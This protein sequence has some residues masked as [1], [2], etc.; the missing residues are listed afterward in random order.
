MPSVRVVDLRRQAGYPLSAPL[1]AEL[2]AVEERGGRA[3]LLLNR[4]GISGAIHCRACGVS[5]RCRSCDVTLTLHRDGRCTAITADTPKRF[6]NS[7]PSV[8]RSSWPGSGGNAAARG[9]ARASRAGARADPARRRHDG[10]RS[11]PRRARAVHECTGGGAD[12]DADGGKGTSLPRVEVAA[13]VDADTGLAF[14]DFRAEERTFQLVTQLAG[15]SGRD[16]PGKV[17]VQT[18]QPDA[19]PFAFAIRHDVA[20]FLARELARR[21]ELSLPTFFSI[22]FHSSSR[23]LTRRCHPGVARAPGRARDPEARLRAGSAPPSAWPPSRAA[24]GEDGLSARLRD[25]CRGGAGA[26][27]RRCVA[28][29]CPPSS[30]SI[31]SRPSGPGRNGHGR[32]G[33]L[34]WL[35]GLAYIGEIHLF[36]RKTD[37]AIPVPL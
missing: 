21:E 30:T 6:L 22:L 24:P 33:Q 32:F 1:L 34:R 9:R 13:V 28:T 8:A 19:M 35:R 12:R 37:E 3:V 26:P 10:A 31:R 36:R 7:A 25:P 17:L 16:A 15:R 27:R 14:P 29:G 5:R 18:F 11:A 20:G 4:R 23:D 2:A